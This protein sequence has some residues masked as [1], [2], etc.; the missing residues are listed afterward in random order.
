MLLAQHHEWRDEDQYDI[1]RVS[2]TRGCFG[3]CRSEGILN[4][5]RG[6]LR[7]VSIGA[8]GLKVDTMTFR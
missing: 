8:E 3:V 4:V 5:G 1:K 7:E 2:G 6:W